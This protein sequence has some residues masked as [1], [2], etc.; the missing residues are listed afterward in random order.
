MAATRS[1]LTP[2]VEFRR[3][4]LYVFLSTLL[5]IAESKGWSVH[6][7]LPYIELPPE[8]GTAV[9]NVAWLFLCFS[10]VKMVTEW[11]D[12]ENNKQWGML[13]QLIVGCI[14]FIA[15]Q[16]F[17]IGSVINLPYYIDELFNLDTVLIS[18]ILLLGCVTGFFLGLLFEL[19][20]FVRSKEERERTS[21]PRFPVAV[22]SVAM[23]AGAL[24]FLGVVAAFGLSFIISG[25]ISSHWWEMYLGT[26]ILISLPGATSFLLGKNRLAKIK[27]AVDMHDSM[28]MVYGRMR[29]SFKVRRDPLFVAAERGDEGAVRELVG[30]GHDPD[31][32]GERGWTPLL[33]AVAQGH[34]DIARY[35]LDCG[36]NPNVGNFIGRT[37]L[38]FASRYGNVGMVRTLLEYGADQNFTSLPIR[39]PRNHP[40]MA[41]AEMGHK[42]IVDLLFEAGADLNIRD[43]DGLTAEDYA[44]SAGHGDIATF[45]RKKRRKHENK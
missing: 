22:S 43:T 35:L 39:P 23:A 8:A 34:D 36:A 41:A 3:W 14:L 25:P 30:S 19:L 4:N 21:L 45:L 28:Y 33:I 32:V 18:A 10:G 15:G 5:I 12:A 42:E 40:L 9:I 6:V 16:I 38:M 31:Q 17:F 13:I 27:V 20:P 44:R 7:R 26:T 2:A 1:P 11:S 29:G 37:P 24:F